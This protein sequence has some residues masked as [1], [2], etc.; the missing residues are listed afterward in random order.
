MKI[1]RKA[2]AKINLGLDVTGKR[3]DGYHIV[4]MIMQNVDL[5]DTLDF[6]DNETGEIVLTAS[7]PKIPTDD[8]NLICKVAKQLQDKFDVKKGA[9]INLVKRIPV[10]AGMAG[11]STDGAAA[12]I[13]LNELWNLGLSKEELCKLA[14]KLGADIPYCIMGGTML[15]EG[16]GEELTKVSDLPPCYI[17]IAK[18][19]IDVSTGWVYKEL[20][21][22]EIVDHP[23]IDG[24][25]KA[26]EKGD[27]HEM[28]DLIGN[29][30][31][32]VTAGKYD[33]IGKIEYIL[34]DNGAIRAFMTGSGPT[35]FAI[36]DDK[37]K[38]EAALKEVE[39]SRL[40]P[41]LFLSGPINPEE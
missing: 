35:V 32:P 17:V 18:P 3:A 39:K 10:A 1:T 34:E 30:L 5:F 38:A 36:F 14:V 6:E 12:Y 7:S 27:I 9:N 40:A 15:A 16:I 41:E 11:G 19:A 37:N 13:A 23:D 24:I 4:R 26:I 33:E 25:K 31:E 21:S 2:Y 8:S 20:D 28:C 29:V 22:K